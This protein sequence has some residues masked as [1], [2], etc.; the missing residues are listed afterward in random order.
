MEYRV[1]GP[2]EVLDASGRKLSLGGVMQQ[3]VL[4]SLLLRAGQTV[5]LDRLVDELWDEPPATAARTIQAYVSRL[6]H[7][8]PDGAIESRRGGYAL[9]LGDAEL[10]LD[11]FEQRAKQGSAALAAGDH[12]Q[13]A[14]LF[15]EALELW[16]GPAL[17]GLQ[18]GS[19]SREAEL[20]EERRLQALEDR[21]E[22]DLGRGRHREAVAELQGLVAG[23]PFRERLRAQLMLA[24]Y[25]SGR[26]TEALEA[27]EEGRKIL[28]D[29]LGLEPSPS[30]RQLQQAV[31]RQ[32]PSLGTDALPTGTVTLLFTDIEGSTRLLRDLGPERY[33]EA[34]AEHRRTVREA[35]A[36]HGGIEVDAQGDGVFVSFTTAPGALAAAREVTEAL[37]SGPIRVRVGVHT[38]SPLLTEAGYVGEDVHR[39]ARIAAAAHGGQ[40]LLS[41][42]TA[43]L[44]DETLVPLGE[45]RLRDLIEPV[46][47]FQLGEST[48]PAP[49]ALG[50]TG[51]PTQAT[52]FV[53]REHELSELLA[54]LRGPQVVT[55]TGAGGSGKTRLALEAASRSARDFRDGVFWVS[56]QSLS[57]PELVELTIAQAVGATDDVVVHL[58]PKR[59]LLLLDNFEHVIEAA[60]KVGDLCSRLPNLKVLITSRE[61]LHLAV[62]HEYPVHPLREAEAITFFGDRA[63]AVKPGFE[64]DEAVAEICRRLDCLPLAL[65]LAAVRVKALST[66]ELLRRLGK[67]LPLL[68][69]GPRDAPER[70]RTLRATI[71]W[72][73]ELLDPEEQRLFAGLAIFRGGS[74]LEAIE[75]VCGADLDTVAA[76]ID[77]SLLRREG[78]RYLMLE[79]IGEF[80]AERLAESDEL[81]ALSRRHAEYYL[82]LA[83]S[84]EDL[85]RSPKAAARL[86]ELERD[87]ENL[88][89]ALAWL[90][91]TTPDRAPQLAVWGL[92]GRLHT[93]G[94]VALER[95]NIIE[96]ARLYR[97]SLELGSR[98]KD[99]LQTA[100]CLAG[101]AV[102]GAKRGK[103]DVAAR[104]WGCVRGFEE[105]SG[106]RLHDVERIRYARVLDAYEEAGRN[107]PDFTLGKAM[108]I[109]D[110]VEY[111]LSHVD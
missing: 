104:L 88:R 93:F 31:L 46:R 83:R 21:L 19:L 27:Y 47:L 63:R 92:A 91:E 49:A 3:S 85:I 106:T 38:G 98:L 53:G 18:S 86:D 44:V 50:G 17:A 7:E 61:P 32:A 75:R 59:A 72:S 24:L 96:A 102:V 95:R 107:G 41:E 64:E 74:T 30:L 34:L 28:H 78:D 81:D 69:G 9:V 26:Q 97:E 105:E 89:A 58:A 45:H 70:Q 101:L 36:R 62:E 25:R 51:L 110:G 99:D 80:A 108:T 56:L 66:Q 11:T 76:L 22:A 71:G 94:D 14:R 90:S 29:E 109:D 100:Y 57:D 16:R 1:L 65:E 35:C 20:L 8:L 111:A 54:H 42:S 6:R 23:Q 82:E 2:L 79:T 5:A 68:T 87:H 33:G 48:F 52:P 73:Y 12:E 103:G 40:V 84:V 67:R 39:A 60:E 43:A 4:A 13:A 15:R 55:L 10:D 77:K 37:A